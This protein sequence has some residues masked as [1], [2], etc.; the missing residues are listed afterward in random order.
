MD[1]QQLVKYAQMDLLLELDRICKKWDIPYFLSG[2][3]L[4]GAVRHDGFIPW[5]DD[6]DIGMLRQHYDRFKEACQT[7]LDPSYILSSWHNDPH[8]PNSFFKLK[9]RGTHYTESIC[10]DS[11][12]DDSIFID[13][14]PYDNAPSNKLLRQL[15]GVQNYLLRKILLL[16]CGCDLSGDSRLRKVLY[17]TLCFLS[18]IRSVEAWKRSTERLHQRYNRKSSVYVTNYSGSYSNET[19]TMRREWIEHTQPHC[20]E[21]LQFPIPTG[22]DAFLRHAY[23]DYMQLPPE[24]QRTGRHSILRIE[25]GDYQIRFRQAETCQ[26]TTTEE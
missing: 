24:H 6:I 4:I 8:S 15:Q 13:I 26:D 1:K 22:Y 16:R 21:G 3:T 11:K 14:F 25:L 2:G 23:G 18:R 9:I 19:E 20:F 7:E 17:G 5:D 12:M 10:A